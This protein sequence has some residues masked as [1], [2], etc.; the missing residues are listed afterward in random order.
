MGV[1]IDQV[2]KNNQLQ[3]AFLTEKQ[4]EQ[5]RKEEERRQKEIEKQNLQFKKD[6]LKDS[7]RILTEKQKEYYEAE[8]SDAFKTL[9]KLNIRNKLINDILL[10]YQSETST[11]PFLEEINEFLQNNYIST[12]KK[13]KN[14]YILAEEAETEEDSEET[15]E[16]GNIFNTIILSIFKLIKYI[17]LFIFEILFFLLK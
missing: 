3:T 14:I 13:L 12:N 16:A 7:E 4:R 11:K 1:F 9:N 5:K 15:E 17:I 10:I 2:Q 8:G 6:I